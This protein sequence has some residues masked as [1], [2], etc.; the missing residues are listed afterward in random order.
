MRAA[1]SAAAAAVPLLVKVLAAAGSYESKD[2][3]TPTV[4]L[5]GDLPGGHCDL[6]LYHGWHKFFGSSYIIHMPCTTPPLPQ[7]RLSGTFY[8]RLK[9]KIHYGVC[10]QF[11]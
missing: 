8:A 10:G 2:K 11:G 6:L 1:A 3:L 4:I 9:V 5:P 7:S